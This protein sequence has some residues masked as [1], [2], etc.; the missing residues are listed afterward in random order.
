MEQYLQQG[1]YSLVGIEERARGRS[2]ARLQHVSGDAIEGHETLWLE[3][4]DQEDREFALRRYLN[5]QFGFA[6]KVLFNPDPGLDRLP[7]G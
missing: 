6:P 3:L 2:W 1:A 7:G 4:A 5:E